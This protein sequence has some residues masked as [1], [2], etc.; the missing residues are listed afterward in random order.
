MSNKSSQSSIELRHNKRITTH[1]PIILNHQNLSM[2]VTMINLSLSGL[3]ATSSIKINPNDPVE[4]RFSL[5]FNDEVIELKIDSQLVH[6]TPVRGQ[7][8]IGLAF[9]PLSS[10]QQRIISNFINSQQKSRL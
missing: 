5:P 10:H 1:R 9:E 7:F 2:G 3:G 6:S 4:V 8:L